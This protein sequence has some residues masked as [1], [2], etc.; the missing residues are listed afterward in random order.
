MLERIGNPVGIIADTTRKCNLNCWYCHSTSGPFYKGPELTGRDIVNIYEASEKAKVFDIT[1][2]GGEPTLWKGLGDAMDASRDLQYPALQLITNATVLSESKLR[3]LKR[4]KLNRILVSLDGDKETHE[5][6]RGQDSYGRTLKGIRALRG[7]VDNIT[8]ISVI[9]NTNFDRWPELTQALID[10]GIKQHHLS[11]VCFAGGAMEIYKGLTNEQFAFVRKT[12]DRIIPNLPDDFSLIFND[13]LINKSRTRSLSTNS[14]GEKYKG[15]HFVVRPDGKVNVAVRAWGRSW[16]ENETLGNLKEESL[17]EMIERTSDLRKIV[18]DKKFESDEERRRKFH[19]GDLSK[20]EIE[21][22]RQDVKF[23]ESGNVKPIYE[24]LKNT[25]DDEC[26][27]DE[28]FYLPLQDS[29]QKI[30]EMLISRPE[31]YRLRSEDGFGFLFDRQTFNITMLRQDEFDEIN[32][33]LSY[34]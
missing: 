3:T 28:I 18:V 19:L 2:T 30:A 33:K 11:P 12:V 29:P 9:D 6:N 14:F 10:M 4:G 22:D 31:R 20:S 23:V 21:G 1:L 16:R 13:I 15:W 25:N 5:Q 32:K 8:I 34:K 24:K 7:V 17:A 27:N 26:E